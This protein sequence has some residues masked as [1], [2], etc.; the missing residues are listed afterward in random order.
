MEC[1]FLDEVWDLLVSMS[2]LQH[3]VCVCVCVCVCWGSHCSTL[4]NTKRKP[5]GEV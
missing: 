1:L 3:S 4:H 5:K 2:S